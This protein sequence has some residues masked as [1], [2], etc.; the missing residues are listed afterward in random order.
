MR[1]L[2]TSLS[3]KNEH[4]FVHRT[5]VY[6]RIYTNNHV[7]VLCVYPLHAKYIY[8]GK[9]IYQANFVYS[10]AARANLF[11]ACFYAFVRERGKWKT[12]LEK[13]KYIH[14]DMKGRRQ[15]RR[16]FLSISVFECYVRGDDLTYTHM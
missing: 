13:M 3:I 10:A 15:R 14:K 8:N 9:F 5:N 4:A 1:T 6:F 2:L 16:V 12:A 7:C 11:D